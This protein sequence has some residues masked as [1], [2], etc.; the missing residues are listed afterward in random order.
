[1]G[2]ARFFTPLNNS[3][4]QFGLFDLRHGFIPAQKFAGAQVR[5]GFQRRD[6][7]SV[8]GGRSAVAHCC[9]HTVTS[10]SAPGSPVERAQQID[11]PDDCEELDDERDLFAAK[12]HKDRKGSS[13][14]LKRELNSRFTKAP[15]SVRVYP[16]M[17]SSR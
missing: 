1:V 17:L 14:D 11:R 13:V 16:R 6:A 4:D 7:A 8:I 3:V 2:H 10:I 5:A 9:A 12:E 15:I